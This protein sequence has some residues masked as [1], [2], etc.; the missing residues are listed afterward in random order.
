MYQYR[1]KPVLVPSCISIM[2]SPFWYLHEA[3]EASHGAEVGDEPAQVDE[4]VVG[5]EQRQCGVHLARNEA[6]PRGGQPH[7]TLHTVAVL[8]H[9]VPAT[10]H[11]I[12]S[13]LS[14][15]RCWLN[16]ISG[17]YDAC[18]YPGLRHRFSTSNGY[19]DSLDISILFRYPTVL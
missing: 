2:R 16:D 15:L 18:K 3:V 4:D 6:L 10:V 8:I 1:E 9:D 7:G 12:Y 17:D 5:G 14:L 19:Y 13:T 11:F